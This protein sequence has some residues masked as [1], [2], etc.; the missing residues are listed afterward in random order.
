ML[1][2]RIELAASI[3]WLFMDFAWMH[4]SS[5]LAV[6]F[7]IPTSLGSLL[8]IPL[9][10]GGFVP[11]AVAGAMAA[12]AFMNSCWMLTDLQIYPSLWLARISF[13]V[14]IGLLAAA[15]AVSGPGTT[16]GEVARLFRRLRARR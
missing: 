12:W 14:G 9:A 13:A 4:D 1:G 11:R 16:F 15:V 7:A 5:G 3:A 10:K 8:A 2:E 6:A